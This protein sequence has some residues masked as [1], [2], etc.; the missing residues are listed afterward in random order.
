MKYYLENKF[1]K[2]YGLSAEKGARCSISMKK[3]N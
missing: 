3:G 1:E 2:N